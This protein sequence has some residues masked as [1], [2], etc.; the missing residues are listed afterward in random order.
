MRVPEGNA[1]GD[2]WRYFEVWE[3]KFVSVVEEFDLG[4]AGDE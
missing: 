3:L 4:G 2:M 1:S